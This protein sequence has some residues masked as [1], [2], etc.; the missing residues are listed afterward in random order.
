M[1]QHRQI[2]RAVLALCAGG[3]AVTAVAQQQ[4]PQQLQ[5]V[6]VT[7]SNIKR[8]DAEAVAPVEIITREQIART[9]QPTIADVLRNLPSNTGG[10]F[11]ESFSNSFAPGAAGISLRGLGQKT[12]LVLIN[13]RRIAGYGFA[14]NLQD[15]FVDLNSIPTS[16]VERVEILKDGA[17]AIYGSD[18]IAGVVNVILRKDFRG[19]E[20]NV[21][22]GR[23]AGNNEYN[24]TLTGGFGDLGANKFNV[25]GVLDFYH[26]DL[27]LMSDTPFGETRDYRGQ[28]GGRNFNSLTAGGTWRQL[29]AAGATT[30]N[31]RAISSCQDNVVTGPQALAQGLTANAAQ[32]AATNTFCSQETNKLLTALPKTDRLGF[33]GRGTYEFS[34]SMSAFAEVGL[35]RNKSFQ[36]FT[37][38]FFAGTTGLTQ[39]AAGLAPFTY[40]INFAPGVA[41]NPFPTRA[42]Y[43]GSL[44]DLGS[45]NVEITSDSARL[46]AG[47][48]YTLGTWDL[49]SA[50]GY[51]RNKVDAANLNRISLAGTSAA[52]GVPSTRQP[53][54][55]TS[56]ASAYNLDDFRV[57]SQALRDSIRADFTRTSTSTLKFIDTKA[58]TELQS[59][60]LPGGP[61]GIAVGAEYRRESLNDAPAAI[62]QSGGVLGQGITATEGSR[63]SYAVFSE[64]RL[65]ILK[66][67]EAQIAGRYDH[68]SDYGSSATPKFGLKYS[69]TDTVALRA[70]YGRGFRA[71][72]LPEISP[73]VA[74]FFTQVIDPQDG[75]IKNV[76]G[77]FAGNPNLKA[78]KSTSLNLGIVFEPAKDFSTSVD[79]YRIRWND[80]VA[81]TSFQKIIDGSCPNP[82]VVATDP[83]CPTTAQVIRDPAN[84]NDVV[85][86]LSNYQNLNTRVTTGLDFDVRYGVPTVGWGKFTTR[87][88]ADYI[89]KFEED[90]VG[91]NDSNAGS[92]TI[93]RLKATASLD[94]DYGPWKATTRWNYTKGWAQTGLPASYFAPQ[95]PNFQTGTYR[96]KT[97]DFYTFDL[98]GSYQINK[99]FMVAAS[100]VNMFD[101]RPPYDPGFSTTFLYDFSQFDVRGRLYRLSV[102]YKM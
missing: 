56:T 11:G 43:T 3:C 15:T 5:R 55:P 68:Y 7:G 66:N 86:I 39:T 102:N 80:V 67:L 47:L 6:E 32:G 53:P 25:F 9:G 48:I 60:R 62:A 49:D 70:N 79:F 91:V 46:L 96:L 1:F 36:V 92:N 81:S 20:A 63:N 73:S 22:G 77:I 13:G 59:V 52:F 75:V 2:T 17:S 33:L 101:R 14:Q 21:A 19:L 18:A 57:N 93:P 35:N 78:E 23:A 95:N 76:S 50:V 51:S 82:P 89:L 65:P 98:Y 84:N 37:N 69:P 16:A 12:T 45:R 26:R 29:T 42:R 40:N 100:V 31:F 27:I 99:N 54:V 97:P 87:L 90:G 64:L 38:P 85:T 10:S 74:T 72:T 71:P 24:A 44:N 88:N 30:Q 8:I 41:G 94:W 58:S 83:P 28:P 4:Q 61:L 34:P